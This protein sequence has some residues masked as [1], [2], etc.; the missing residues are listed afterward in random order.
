M[1]GPN[2]ILI[3]H[4]TIC[5]A[6]CLIDE[7]PSRPGHS[8]F[9]RSQSIFRLL[10]L[11]SLTEAVVLHDTLFTL[12]ATLPDY[13]DDLQLR[14][15]LIEAGILKNYT[16]PVFLEELVPAIVTWISS[17]TQ[18]K[19]QKHQAYGPLDPHKIA[20]HVTSMVDQAGMKPYSD[21]WS[22][23]IDYLNVAASPETI[24]VY[25]YLSNSS[26]L[27]IDDLVEL[28]QAKDLFGKDGIV[29]TLGAGIG[30]SALYD[31]SGGYQHSLVE[32]RSLLY[33][34]AADR[35]RIPWYPDVLRVPLMV[36]LHQNLRS[37]LTD[38][39]YT[40]VARAFNTTVEDLLSEDLPYEAVIPP[41][42]ALLLSRCSKR[43]EVI[44]K[45]LEL[46]DEFADFRKTFRELEMQRRE[47]RSIKE[48]RA[49]RAKTTRLLQAVATKYDN[50]DQ[51]IMETTLGYAPDVINILANPLDPGRYKSELLKKPYEWISN[52]WC[53]RPASRLFSVTKKLEQL[54]LYGQLAPRVFGIEITAS[55]ASLIRTYNSHMQQLLAPPE[56]K[57][58]VT[59]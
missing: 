42:G 43:E 32:L 30:A 28:L 35:I 34:Q 39:I 3:G 55:D 5:E 6:A 2:D 45:L 37:S 40:L 26:A 1:P 53:R 17:S 18:E 9:A 7:T 33:W 51:S 8:T 47:A 15:R 21:V 57:Q 14:T 31:M 49:I 24:S 25:D 27:N 11:C 46:R 54:K 12:P 52:W 16:S 4:T 50:P 20:A 59:S 19:A 38:Q 56:S 58:Q 13:V 44:D 22:S 48:L 36:A 10:E 23:G 29:K 41:L